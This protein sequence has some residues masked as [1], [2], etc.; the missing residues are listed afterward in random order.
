VDC[1]V[2]L[3]SR[4]GFARSDLGD[5]VEAVDEIIGLGSYLR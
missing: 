4:D 1:L 3:R 2:G 5:F